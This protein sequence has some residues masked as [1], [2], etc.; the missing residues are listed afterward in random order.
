MLFGS[1]WYYSAYISISITM[2][3]LY[4]VHEDETMLNAHQVDNVARDIFNRIQWHEHCLNIVLPAEKNSSQT[5]RPRKHQFQ[6]PSCASIGFFSVSL[7]TIVFLSLCS[8]WMFITA[9]GSDGSIVCSIVA[10]F[11]CFLLQ[12]QLMNSCTELDAILH[13]RVL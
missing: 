13:E 10:V 3:S 4:I 6:F 12:R 11:F 9:R 5:L 8:F 1:K 2:K 7:S